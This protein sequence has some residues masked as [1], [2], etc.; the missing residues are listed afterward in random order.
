MADSIG[1]R[2]QQCLVCLLDLV[3][4]GQLLSVLDQTIP[5]SSIL[6]VTLSGISIEAPASILT[7][8]VWL[9]RCH[10]GYL[11]HVYQIKFPELD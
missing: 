6:G 7:L 11:P 9:G 8:V 3:N 1:I 4:V 5:G 10:A 2:F